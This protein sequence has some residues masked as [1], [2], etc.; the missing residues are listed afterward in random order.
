MPQTTRSTPRTGTGTGRFARPGAAQT[1]A[2]RTTPR[3]TP[4]TR[5]A[6]RGRTP[7]M[8]AR[9]SRSKPKQKT[10]IAGAL[11]G[12]LPTGAASKATPNSKKGKAG[13]F[14]AI[15]GLAGVAFK[16]R[17]KLSGM[18]GRKGGG[19]QHASQPTYATTPTPS[20]APPPVQPK[21]TTTGI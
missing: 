11:T 19:E 13:G 8:P 14:A 21:D 18:L 6:P 3:R 2:R 17:D 10:G 15:A 1:R 9:F 20:P 7:Q 4:A 12:L 16:N 5:T